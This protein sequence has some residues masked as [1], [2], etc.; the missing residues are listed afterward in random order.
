VTATLPPAVVTEIFRKVDSTDG[1]PRALDR[2]A[3]EHGMMLAE[4]RTLLARRRTPLVRRPANVPP[5]GE[6]Q[7]R[8]KACSACGEIK[9]YDDFYEATNT[10]SGRMSQCIK[11]NNSRPPTPSKIV[12][13]RARNRAYQ[14][15][16][17]A[18]AEEFKAIM[19]R[20]LAAAAAEHARLQQVAAGRPDAAIARLR[21]G[22]K[23][24]GETDAAERLDV[25]RCPSCH[26]HHDAAHQCPGCGD[27]TPETAPS[28]RAFEVRAWADAN[29]VEVPSRGPVPQRV[30]EAF[31]TA[32][33]ERTAS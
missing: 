6:A 17:N 1:S 14:V 4:L 5:S 25:A 8:R 19:V 24:K 11:C 16:A 28:L 23:R 26:T 33:P 10:I 21:P 32:H 29:G 27:T 9:P 18:H 31:L 30:L 3:A 15:L 20:E 12:R 22:P 2:I 13:N 7:G